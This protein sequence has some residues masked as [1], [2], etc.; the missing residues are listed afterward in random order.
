MFPGMFRYCGHLSTQTPQ[1]KHLAPHVRV[2][3]CFEYRSIKVFI[4]C[5]AKQV[6]YYTNSNLSLHKFELV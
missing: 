2:A 1:L 4:K 3:K 5:W 6:L